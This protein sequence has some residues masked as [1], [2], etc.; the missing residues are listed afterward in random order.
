MRSNASQDNP[1]Y[2]GLSGLPGRKS[3]QMF[4]FKP[5]YN[6]HTEPCD[7]RIFCAFHD[8]SPVSKDSHF[9]W[10]NQESQKELVVA[11]FGG[12]VRKPGGQDRED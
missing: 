12:E 8:G 11:H 5:R 2:E 6:G 7:R 1:F 10:R 9:I 3:V 4:K